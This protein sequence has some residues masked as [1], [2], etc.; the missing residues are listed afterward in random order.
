MYRTVRN[1]GRVAA[2]RVELRIATQDTIKDSAL[3]SSKAVVGTAIVTFLASLLSAPLTGGAS[4]LLALFGSSGGA[5]AG[6]RVARWCLPRLVALIL[7]L[8]LHRVFKLCLVLLNGTH[9][10][11]IVLEFRP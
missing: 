7:L 1:G 11:G 3:A 6:R 9:R 8:L 4:L 2:G 10:V 5:I